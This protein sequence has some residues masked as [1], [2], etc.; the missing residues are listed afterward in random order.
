LNA[1]QD[2]IPSA[3]TIHFCAGLTS[4][5]DDADD[6]DEGGGGVAAADGSSSNVINAD[7]LFQSR[8]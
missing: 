3:E 4:F 1:Y 5:V 7:C 8:H 6:G 2:D